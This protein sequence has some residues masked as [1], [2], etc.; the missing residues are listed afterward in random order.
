M[1]CVFLAQRAGMD[2]PNEINDAKLREEGPA[3]QTV[4]SKS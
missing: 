4:C 1:Q 3:R 2:M